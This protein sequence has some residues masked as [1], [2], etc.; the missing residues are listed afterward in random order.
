M[1]DNQ[2]ASLKSYAAKITLILAVSLG[3]FGIVTN[4]SGCNRTV[5]D[6][7]YNFNYAYIELQDGT[8]IEG[9]V[10]SWHDY[11]DGDQLQI[12]ING[13][14]YLV[15]ASNCTMIYNPKLG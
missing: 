4:F 13:V 11:E 10:E 1:T 12:K 2:K 3:A 6:V 5:L 7:N 14:T 8:V 9:R 15:H